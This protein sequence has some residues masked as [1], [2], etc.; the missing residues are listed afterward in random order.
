MAIRL[1]TGARNAMVDST[2]LRAALADGTMK[3]FSGSQPTTAD[4]A[5]QG[6]LLLQVTEDAGSFTPGSATNGLEF[7][8]AADGAIE[9][10]AA[11]IWRGL[12]VAE[13]TAG[14]FRFQANALDAGGASTT[15][16]RI[17]GT[18]GKSGS[19][20][21]AILSDVTFVVAQSVTCDQCTFTQ[22]AG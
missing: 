2:G 4:N 19:G 13:G 10:A 8:A 16:V 14:W 7:D 9:K 3:I 22:P 1:S 20:A 6:T 12:A 17:D 18:V 5:E 15:L 11:E 21:D